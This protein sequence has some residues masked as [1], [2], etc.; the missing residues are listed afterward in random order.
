MSWKEPKTWVDQETPTATDFNTEIRD[1]LNA[2]ST[3]SHTG[4][5]GD[6]SATL[7]SVDHID[8]DEGGALS[9][10][11]GGHTRFAANTDGT[12]RI[13]PDGG[14][15]KTLSDTT[16]THQVT[17]EAQSNTLTA[18]A[19][20]SSGVSSSIAA[21]RTNG[22]T[23]GDQHR[24]TTTPAGGTSVVIV[25][26]QTLGVQDNNLNSAA[27]GTGALRLLVD[28]SQQVEVTKAYSCSSS[29]NCGHGSTLMAAYVD[30]DAANASTN[31]DS[32]SKVTSVSSGDFSLAFSG[33][34]Q[35]V[36]VTD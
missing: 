35:I 11:A 9:T 7:D 15:E 14:S 31:Y 19:E 13:F 3:H 6:G 30:V 28:G 23:Y 1:N 18:D 33:G 27:S 22:S 17:E 26:T 10:P 36:E 20:H 5:A 25:G 29:N 24:V 34:T 8:L 2:L 4:A 21:G 32:E 12:L 16:H